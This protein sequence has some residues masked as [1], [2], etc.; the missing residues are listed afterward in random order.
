MAKAQAKKEKDK[1]DREAFLAKVA[2]PL[3]GSQVDALLTLAVGRSVHEAIRDVAKRR[4]IEPV[5]TEVKNWN[6][7]VM[8]Q[9]DYDAA[10]I[11]AGAK[12]TDHEKARLAFDLL[13]Q[14]SYAETVEAA[15][16]LI[17]RP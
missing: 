5:M 3:K 7:K 17:T 1:K 10:L 16:K 14:S 11:Q 8:K 6:N 9:R 4:N 15:T 2:W 13:L 12:M